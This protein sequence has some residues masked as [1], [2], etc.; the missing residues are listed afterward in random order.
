M[1]IFFLLAILCSWVHSQ[2]QIHPTLN[3]INFCYQSSAQVNDFVL[4]ERNALDFNA[5]LNSYPH[6]D[7]VLHGDFKWIQADVAIEGGDFIKVNQEIINDTVLRLRLFCLDNNHFDSIIV[8]NIWVQAQGSGLSGDFVLEGDNGFLAGVNTRYIVGLNVNDPEPVHSYTITRPQVYDF[9]ENRDTFLLEDIALGEMYPCALKFSYQTDNSY[10]MVFETTDSNAVLN[11]LATLEV[12]TSQNGLLL[13]TYT[14]EEHQIILYFSLSDKALFNNNI[15]NIVIGG[16]EWINGENLLQKAALVWNKQLSDLFFWDQTIDTLAIFNRL[17]NPI[18]FYSNLSDDLEFC[19]QSEAINELEAFPLGGVFTWESDNGVISGIQ[20]EFS[21]ISWK[22]DSIYWNDSLIP[23]QSGFNYNGSGISF[24]P[25]EPNSKNLLISYTYQNENCAFTKELEIKAY[26]SQIILDPQSRFFTLDSITENMGIKADTLGVSLLHGWNENDDVFWISDS[27]FFRDNT[28][29]TGFFQGNSVGDNYFFP[30][31]HF[32]QNMEDPYAYIQYVVPQGGNKCPAVFPKIIKVIPPDYYYNPA[33]WIQME[34]PNDINDLCLGNDSI[35]FWVRRDT[36]L[37]TFHERESE[38]IDFG[39]SNRIIADSARPKIQNIQSALNKAQWGLYYYDIDSITIFNN[40]VAFY[41]MESFDRSNCIAHNELNANISPRTDTCNKLVGDS[42]EFANQQFRAISDWIATPQNKAQKVVLNTS[43]LSD[44]IGFLDIKIYYT[45]WRV[46]LD[47]SKSYGVE[48]DSNQLEH[49][50]RLNFQSRPKANIFGLEDYNCSNNQNF[51]EWSLEG[52]DQQFLLYDH[53]Q[54]FIQEIVPGA[55]KMS[56]LDTGLLLINASSRFENSICLQNFWD[57]IY[58]YHVPATQMMN[59]I[60]L[61][62]QALVKWHIN[63]L[64]EMFNIQ[65]TYDNVNISTSDSMIVNLGP[66]GEHIIAC[67]YEKIFPNKACPVRLLDTVLIGNYPEAGM[68][69][70]GWCA[71]MNLEMQSLS[72]MDTSFNQSLDQVVWK[73]GNNVLSEDSIY[74][75]NG[76][77]FE[78]IKLVAIS[79][80]NCKDSITQFIKQLSMH[81][82]ENNQSYFEDFENSGGWETAD[83][84]GWAIQSSWNWGAQSG[85]ISNGSRFWKTSHD[86][87]NS[88]LPYQQSSI[89]T[90]CFNLQNSATPILHFDLAID[91]ELEMDGLSLEY[92]YI[93]QDDF[94]SDLIWSKFGMEGNHLNWYNTSY[95]YAQPGNPIGP[96]K[97][98]SGYEDY[99]FKH[100]ACNISDI[101][102]NTADTL[103]IFR[104]SFASNDGNPPSK[105]WEGVGIDNFRIESDHNAILLENF[106]HE[107]TDA[108]WVQEF[109]DSI[110]GSSNQFSYIQYPIQYPFGD[111]L[112][113]QNAAALSAR[114]LQ[115]VYADQSSLFINGKQRYFAHSNLIQDSLIAAIQQNFLNINP[116]AMDLNWIY[117]EG[118][119]DSIKISL[120]GSEM[121]E[122]TRLLCYYTTSYN[123]G[124]KNI[125]LGAL[126]GINGVPIDSSI[127]TYYFDLEEISHLPSGLQYTLVIIVQ[128]FEDMRV[129]AHQN[130]SNIYSGEIYFNKTEDQTEEINVKVYPNPC[131]EVLYFK[132]ISSSDIETILFITPNGEVVYQT[133]MSSSIL[134]IERLNTGWYYVLIQLQEGQWGKWIYK[135]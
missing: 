92:A 113:E 26:G 22:A 65:W 69:F 63:D 35:V 115:Y 121:N 110:G 99:E 118:L 68:K 30:M 28:N 17:E 123:E 29:L 8:S 84:Y 101:K 6:V 66:S 67:H 109:L 80:L 39:L 125:Y 42:V 61:C 130:L 7:L 133:G 34:S 122:H 20:E 48:I 36:V 73:N 126:N 77:N 56:D 4:A 37:Q 62:D 43:L 105:Y 117:R 58:V 106:T 5:G 13:D 59:D 10:Q 100:V 87:M 52:I 3:T 98:W 1:K 120:T 25:L 103:I 21:K 114:S 47:S 134:N 81:N 127:N 41:I 116:V 82:I 23:N 16:I 91:T 108:F 54:N 112:F 135:E 76:L 33:I 94:S 70:K 64:G 40:D 83:A 75:L 89:F 72:H 79:N 97:G 46:Q 78:Y 90:P 12:E 50:L 128:D 9:C 95:I 60:A 119:K 132:N 31:T 2:L 85:N 11:T 131:K 86:T 57:T 15:N 14:I 19:T 93:H 32:T 88:Y 18:Q 129:L 53:E 45:Q 44:T 124:K 102:K 107:D 104:F 74:S 27:L 55:D 24:R 71:N 49:V 51:I 111:T 96:F 38:D